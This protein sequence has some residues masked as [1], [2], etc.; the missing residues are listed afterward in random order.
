M[1][2]SVSRILIET[3]VRRTIRE[4][5]E[6]P[7]RSVRNLVDLALHFA[8]GRFQKRFLQ[9]AQTM[10]KNENSLYYRVVTDTVS[11]VNT[12]RLVKFGMNVG[13]NS[14]TQGAATIRQIEHQQHFNVPWSVSVELTDITYMERKG[15]YQELL[16]QGKELGIYTWMLHGQEDCTK[17][18][19]LAAQN[20]DCAFVLFCD[21]A[22]VTE[23][24]L[25]KAE[26]CENLMI[27]VLYAEGAEKVCGQLRDAGF[28]YAVYREYG[29][30]DEEKIYSGEFFD[31][32]ERLHGVM[33]ALEAEKGCPVEVQRKVYRHVVEE[34]THQK[35]STVAWDIFQDSMFIDSIISEDSC[36]VFFDI[37][38]QLYTYEEQ[39]ARR[40][41]NLFRQP[42]RQILEENFPKK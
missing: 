29:E 21:P 39:L 38:G 12:D 40:E 30:A 9:I 23:Q 14:C 7:K 34:R 2:T 35:R 15:E 8:D 16:E 28:L 1:N 4:I 17:L 27:C 41:A 3:M 10:L 20:D 11:H 22:G 19:D 24:F 31:G 26:D 33:T 6:S 25:E 32:P 5:Q 18:L 37:E 36:S 13:F 42:L